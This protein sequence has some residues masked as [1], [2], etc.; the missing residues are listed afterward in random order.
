MFSP[1]EMFKAA[2]EKEKA[3]RYWLSSEALDT[4]FI[5]PEHRDQH[6]NNLEVLICGWC[7]EFKKVIDRWVQ[8]VENGRR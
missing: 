7:R 1:Q 3:E 8:E 4:R 5:A 2:Q 6:Q